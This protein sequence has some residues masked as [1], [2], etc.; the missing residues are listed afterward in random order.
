MNCPTDKKIYPLHAHTVFSLLDGVSTIP[1]Y[2][3]YCKENGLEACSCT[4]HGY[5]MGLYD[6]VTQGNKEGIKG[7]PGCEVYLHPGDDYV[8]ASHQS[9][10]PYYFHL[11][12]WAMNKKGYSNL[13]EL[14]NCS[15]QEGRVLNIF[16]YKPRVT[17]QDLADNNEGLICGS[18][19]IAGPIVSPY[20]RG[21]IDMANL[22][23]NRLMDIFGDKGRLFMEVMPHRVDKDWRTRGVIQVDSMV[24][25][26]YTFDKNDIITTE[27]GDMTA[28]QAMKRGVAE[29]TS[30]VTHRPQQYSL[31]NRNITL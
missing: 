13:L 2:L 1:E 17:W 19:C 6:L 22:N 18:G 29:I 16:G 31:M 8:L 27:Q 14:S 15:W 10:K 20:M 12:L 28:E 7:I 30:S 24:G 26:T 5:V 21:E 4:D 9:K 3:Q 25:L 23:A 11:T